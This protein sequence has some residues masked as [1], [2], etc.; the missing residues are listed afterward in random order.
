LKKGVK[1]FK[2]ITKKQVKNFISNTIACLLIL[3]VFATTVY[4]PGYDFANEFDIFSSRKIVENIKNLELNMTSV[5]YFKNDEGEWE[6]YKRVHGEEN[7]IWVPLKKIPEDLKN[8]FIAIED[9]AFKTHHGVN[10]RRTFLAVVNQVF[11]YSDVDFGAST[12]TQQLIKNLTWDNAK[13]YTRKLREIVRATFVE[14]QCSKD[15]ILE[16]YLNTIALGNGINGVQV[17]ANYYFNKDVSELNMTEC[18]AIAA[19]TKNPSRYNPVRSMEENTERR[20]VVLKEMYEQKLISYEELQSAYYKKITLDSSQKETLDTDINDY[21]IDTLI[22]EVIDDLAEKY[23][24]GHKIASQMF[25]NGGFKIYSTMTPKVQSTM[26]EVYNNRKK[27]FN[28]KRRNDQDEMEDVQSAMAILDYEGHILGVVGGV[29]EKTVNRGLNRADVPRQPGSTMKPLG[30]YSLVIENDIADYTSKVLDKPVKNYYSYGKWGPK[31]WFGSYMGEVPL[32]YALR[33][34]M[35]AVPVRLIDKVGIENSFEFLTKDLG[36]KHLVESDKNS[37][38]L[39]LG[40]CT[41]GITP[42]E[43]ASAFAVFGNDGIY[44]KPTTYYKV[45][46]TNGDVILEQDTK[47]KRVIS[48]ATATIMNHLLQEVV[49]KDGGTGRLVGGFNWR[50][51]AYA[52]T[53]TSSDTKDSWLVGGTPYYVGSVWY[54]FDHNMRVYNTN[55][56]KTVW[57]DIMKEL[58]EDLPIIEFE[59]SESVYRKGDGYYKNGT[60][61]GITVKEEDYLPEEELEEENTSSEN[62]SSDVTSSDIATPSTPTTPDQNNNSS[63]LPDVNNTQ[64]GNVSSD[65]ESNTSSETPSE[66][67]S[68]DTPTDSS[69]SNTSSNTSSDTTTSSPGDSSE[70]NT[71]AEPTNVE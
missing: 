7:R 53:G 21:F 42:I 15:E 9:E 30:V 61:P 27:Y 67:P 14:T 22:E 41:Y 16:A 46:A 49:Y 3:A 20:Q 29:G 62:I 34:S 59:D 43:S 13:A 57:R 8:A 2:K 1:R 19:I 17:A 11:K 18:A 66:T 64:S 58:H 33:R 63:T 31:E 35:N 24:C 60:K 36:F 28:E 39:A 4:L 55:A 25:Y 5:I 23:E 44:H 10:W 69:N 54:G 12:I 56:A 47:G 45:V 38:S 50:M 68:Q 48:S 71:S 65:V 6:E 37:A 26:E 52:K 32:N 51:K 40:G 70:D